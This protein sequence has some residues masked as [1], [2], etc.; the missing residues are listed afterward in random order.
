LPGEGSMRFHSPR[1]HSID[2]RLAA[3]VPTSLVL[4]LINI[5]YKPTI[6]EAEAT[7]HSK[8]NLNSCVAGPVSADGARDTVD[9]PVHQHRASGTVEASTL[10]SKKRYEHV[11][12]RGGSGVGPVIQA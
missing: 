4:L 10:P 11:I 1:H 8:A 5:R 7:S 3:S 6:S 2:P 9:R 12:C